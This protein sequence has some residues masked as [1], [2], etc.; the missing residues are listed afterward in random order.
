[1]S[2]G[3]FGFNKS[4]QESQAYSGL[5]GTPYFDPIAGDVS[6]TSRLLGNTA[7]EYAASP[8][9]F[10][11]GQSGAQLSNTNPATGLPM[12]FNT[13]LLGI[14]NDLYSRAS[15]GG[16]MRGQV[17]PESTGGVVGSAI[18]N[19]GQF[20]TPYIMDWQKYVT[21]LPETIKNSRLGFLQNTIGATSPLIGSQSN[22]TGNAFGFNVA[23]QGK[24]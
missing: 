7:R 21:G 13:A 8:F 10:F 1:M 5:R 24:G 12:S 16:A 17:T 4:D 6:K 22:Y 18:Q 14:T 3:S 11:Q 9:G 2:G 20:L 15:A 19:I 23:A